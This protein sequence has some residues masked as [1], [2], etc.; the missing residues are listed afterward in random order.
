MKATI[1]VEF[2]ANNGQ[3][4][5]V[6]ESA[7]MR[8]VGALAVAIEHGSLTGAPTEVKGGSVTTSIQEREI[9]D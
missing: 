4:K 6:L 2:E 1:R 7:L 8:G 5:Y 9:M 3:P